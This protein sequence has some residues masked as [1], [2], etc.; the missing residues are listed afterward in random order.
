MGLNSLDVG[1]LQESTW[2]ED[3][4]LAGWEEEGDEEEGEN[5]S[6]RISL[7]VSSASSPRECPMRLEGLPGREMPVRG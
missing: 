6:T 2:G 5:P 1:R 3:L 4:K 7:V